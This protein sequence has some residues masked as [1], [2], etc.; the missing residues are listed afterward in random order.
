M[1]VAQA[2][3][4]PDATLPHN[5]VV[6][7]DSDNIIITGGTRRGANLFHSFSQFSVR[8]EESVVFNSDPTANNIV[9]RVTGGDASYINGL[10]RTAS[11]INLYIINPN[12]IYLD[13]HASLDINGSLY[14]STA[15]S[16]KF[17]DD[18]PPLLN[19][20]V[21]IGLQWS[22]SS[23][24]IE[25]NADLAVKDLNVAANNIMITSNVTSTGEINLFATTI[26]I[27]RAVIKSMQSGNINLQAEYISIADGRIINNS[28]TNQDGGD[29]N[30]DASNKFYM[31]GAQTGLFVDTSLDSN[32]NGGSIYIQAP[33]I[34]INDKARVSIT[35]QGSGRSG[36]IQLVTNN[37]TINGGIL[38]TETNSEGGNL[39]VFVYNLITLRENATISTTS[40]GEG[41][42]ANINVEAGFI[43]VNP[44]EDND[45]TTSVAQENSGQ[46]KIYSN[47][48][49]GLEKRRSPTTRSD[50]SA[51]SPVNITTLNIDPSRGVTQ[52]TATVAD[53]SR[54]MNQTCSNRATANS[55]TIVGRG[56]LPLN[57]TEVLNLNP[58]WIDWRHHDVE[59]NE[60]YQVSGQLVEATEWK[61]ENGD[62][63]LVTSRQI[64]SE[65][66]E[67]VAS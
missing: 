47:A 37:L 38:S 62:I 32:R 30:I 66:L 65:S 9:M 22:S 44:D 53:V 8:K 29:I 28:T 10:I 36:D 24:R 14:L 67:C 45:I 59:E 2:Q 6:S 41:D 15:E 26:N 31:T 58:G 12:G 46:I 25:V 40:A 18:N 27:D 34:E 11:N 51:T 60:Q 5:S 48:I 57:A 49:F 17:L 50:I 16:W 63:K 35:S 42:G 7:S 61:V 23:S 54:Q 64:S 4:V 13:K 52:L 21:P 33:N 56:G 3:V 55:F 1:A 19:I 43:L 20:S 39:K